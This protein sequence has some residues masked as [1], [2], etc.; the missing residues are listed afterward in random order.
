VPHTSKAPAWG[1]ERLPLGRLQAPATRPTQPSRKSGVE[2]LTAFPSV[3][4]DCET[5]P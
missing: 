4:T 1:S 3:N 5:A 2:S